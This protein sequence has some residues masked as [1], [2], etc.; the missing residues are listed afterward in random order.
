MTHTEDSSNPPLLSSFLPLPL[1]PPLPF[2]IL[3][4]MQASELME[5]GVPANCLSV[6]HRW[7]GPALLHN[8]SGNGV[9]LSSAMT[10]AKEA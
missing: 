1:C 3:G 9:V 2:P 4:G 8:T 10:E 6:P 7:A 5:M